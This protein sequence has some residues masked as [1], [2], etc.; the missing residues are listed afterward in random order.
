[1]ARKEKKYHYIY[2]IT[3]LKNNRYYIGMH[4]TDNLEDGYFGGGKRIKNSVK[5]HGKDVHRKEILEFFESRDLLRQ[6]EIELVNEELLKD[7]MC[8]N[9]AL[10]GE[11]GFPL[12]CIEGEYHKKISSKGGKS[13]SDRLKNDSELFEKH[14]K[15]SSERLKKLHKL[16]GFRYDTFKGKKHTEESKNK[17]RESSKGMGT[18]EKN[19]Q[20]GTIWITNGKNN[21]K[22]KKDLSIPDG[23]YKGRI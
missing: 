8:M 7:S 17:M 6:R 4:S 2:K 20:F 1:M 18:G 16:G 10:G 23:W 3:C 12:E 15:L 19:S 5:K 22:I 9:I 13:T 21:R 11:G 14:K